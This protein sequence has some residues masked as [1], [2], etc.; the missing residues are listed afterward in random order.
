[1]R[2]S[3]RDQSSAE[4]QRRRLRTDGIASTQFPSDARSQSTA[5]K[6]QVQHPISEAENVHECDGRKER[7]KRKRRREGERERERGMDGMTYLLKNECK[8]HLSHKEALEQK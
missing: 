3:E 2:E 4:K 8:I 7:K 5:T 6:T 1:M